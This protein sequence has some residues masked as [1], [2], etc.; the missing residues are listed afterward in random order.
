ME[1]EA[2]WV[3]AVSYTLYSFHG[4]GAELEQYYI[5]DQAIF[6]GRVR[7]SFVGSTL[8]S[9]FIVIVLRR[10]YEY[11]I[12]QQCSADLRLLV[13]SVLYFRTEDSTVLCCTVQNFTV[14]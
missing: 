6:V 2:I 5:R 14:P 7:F 8:L 3:K 12:V 1:F 13:D 11:R 9:L 4:T 10:C